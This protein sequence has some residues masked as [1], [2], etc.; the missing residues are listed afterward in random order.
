[1]IQ[2]IQTVYLALAF[3]ITA[4][5]LSLPV[6][7]FSPEG[8]GADTVMFNLWKVLPEGT[9]SFTV[10]PLFALLLLTCPIALV[11]IFMF[12]NRK[13]QSKLCVCNILLNLCW[14]VVYVLYGYVWTDDGMTFRPA[15]AACM[16]IVCIILYL[17]AR[18]GIIKDEQLVRA[19]DRIR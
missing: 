11:A 4:V 6:G 15:F 8:M 18:R 2:R 5:C 12:K 13:L 10:W 1:M 17:L 14:V 19:A 16:P 3:I 9:L 7:A